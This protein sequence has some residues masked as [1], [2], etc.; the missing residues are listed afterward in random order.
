MKHFVLD[1]CNCNSDWCGLNMDHFIFYHN[2]EFY[3]ISS[4]SCMMINDLDQKE[5]IITSCIKRI[6]RTDKYE[7]YQKGGRMELSESLK[8]FRLR[9]LNMKRKTFEVNFIYFYIQNQEQKCLSSIITYLDLVKGQEKLDFNYEK[10]KEYLKKE[11]LEFLIDGISGLDNLYDNN[12]IWCRDGKVDYE[13]VKT[14][15]EI[16]KRVRGKIKQKSIINK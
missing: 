4:N 2:F 14:I 16:S 9:N 1:K 6:Y 15:D 8:G 10:A 3:L 12:Q 11:K 13:V 5:D 7:H